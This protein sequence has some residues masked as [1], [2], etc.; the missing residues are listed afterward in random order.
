MKNHAKELN[1]LTLNK[2]DEILNFEKLPKEVVDYIKEVVHFRNQLTIETER[3]SALYATSYLEAVFDK[4]FRK[5]LI[6]N[7]KHLDELLSFNGALGTFSNNINISYSIGLRNK[8]IHN[9]L[10][11]IRKVRNEF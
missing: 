4:L 8:D 2:F 1:S 5:K 9:D 11:I 7:K 6:G 10:H 3:G